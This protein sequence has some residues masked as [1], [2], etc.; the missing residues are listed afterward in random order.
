MTHGYIGWLG[1]SPSEEFNNRVGLKV[2]LHDHKTALFADVLARGGVML[3]VSSCQED[4][5]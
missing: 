4:L 2:A 1:L 5:N 3:V